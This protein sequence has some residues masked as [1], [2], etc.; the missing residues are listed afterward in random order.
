MNLNEMAEFSSEKTISKTLHETEKVKSVLICMSEGQTS[1]QDSAGCKI[2]VLIH[3]G[4]G[5]ISANGE[6]QEV[7]EKDLILFERKDARMLKS[8]TKLTAVVTSI[9]S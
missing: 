6:E 1:L 9:Y 4:S 2:A 7:G 8:K 3:S 5:T